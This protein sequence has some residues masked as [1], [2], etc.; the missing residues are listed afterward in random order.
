MAYSQM[1]LSAVVLVVA[2]LV[3]KAAGGMYACKCMN[4]MLQAAMPFD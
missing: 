1:N 4:Y 2:L 3:V